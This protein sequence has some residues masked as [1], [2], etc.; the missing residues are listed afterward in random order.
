MATA[1]QLSDISFQYDTITVLSIA[2]LK[3]TAN[4]TTAVIGPN[5]SGKST[6]LNLLAF[7]Q[8]PSTGRL[9][10]FETSNE[11]SNLHDLRKKVGFIAQK[12][13][14][15]RGSV[16][17]N[18]ELALKLSNT[19]KLDRPARIRKSLE[20][21]NIDHLAGQQSSRLSGGEKQKV[22][23]ARTLAV[24]PEVLIMDEPFSYL[25]Q[26]SV[27]VMESFI[28]HYPKTLIFSTHTLLQGQALA[29]QVVTLVNGQPVQTP[30]VNLFHGII[31][32]GLFNTGKI[33]IV[34]PKAVNSGKH[35]AIDPGQ[36]VISREALA[37]S[38]RN[39]F[40]GRIT[41]IGEAKGNVR[42]CVDAGESF[43]VLIT[44]QALQ[45]LQLTLGDSVW[46]N[47]KSN[48]VSIF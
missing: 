12:P 5:G 28:E 41:N 15:L 39:H 17:A 40:Q 11:Q 24:E 33:N 22:A 16:E 36:I 31:V 13:Y 2:D 32:K 1:Y 18:I 48:A 26:A 44:H 10:F 20:R 46:V 25:D 23:L 9:P 42:L 45:E 21:L 27:Q 34:L 29:D 37:S 19:P 47:F 7:L 38:M 8:T 30:L 14:L 6:L 43:D 35:I 4:Q 3:I